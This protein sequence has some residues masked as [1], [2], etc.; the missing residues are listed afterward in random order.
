MKGFYNKIVSYGVA[1]TVGNAETYKRVK[2][3]NIYTLIWIHLTALF[4]ITDC[5]QG[6]LFERMFFGHIVTVF[7]TSSLFFI[8]FLNYKEKYY[9]AKWLFMITALIVFNCSSIIV[10]PGIYTE[11]YFF[12]IPGLSLSLF[13]RQWIS[14]MF[15]VTAV[16]CFFLPYHV[17]E[18]Y[19]VDYSNRID[20]PSMTSLF[21]AIYLLFNYFKKLNQQNEDLLMVER[22]RVI[23]DKVILEKQEKELRELNDFKSHFFVNLS[24]EIRTPLTLIQ[25]YTSQIKEGSGK[26]EI[27]ENVKVIKE[28]TH[29]MQSIINDIMDLSKMDEKQFSIS[30]QEVVVARLLEKLAADF[31]PLFEKKNI[32]FVLEMI[33]DEVVIAVDVDLFQKAIN[34]L[35]TNALKFTASGGRVV[36]KSSFVE[37]GFQIC[38]TDSGIGI[39]SAELSNVFKRFYQVENDITK[40]EGSGIGLAFTKSIVE[41]HHF[42]IRVESKENE[43]TK[44]SI[45]IPEGRYKINSLTE[46]RAEKAVL[47]NS[48]LPSALVFNNEKQSITNKPRILVV[49]DHDQMRKYIQTVLMDYETVEAENGKEALE[50][51]KSQ[52]FDLILTDYMMPVMNGEALVREI[53]K[54]GY[55]TPILVLT[56]RTDNHGK[57][58]MLR[59]GI[60]GYLHKPFLEEELKLQVKNALQLYNNVKTFGDQLDAEERESLNAYAEKFNRKINDFILQHIDSNTLSVEEIAS[61]LNMSRSTLNRKTKAILG[62]NVK[63]LIMEARL[64]KARTF[65]LENPMATK[66]EVSAVV[67]I[68]N[69]TH[70][71]RKLEERFGVCSN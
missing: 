36:L 33:D 71:F 35:L 65:Q 46:Q 58:N 55:N 47:L 44:F 16:F 40:S 32:A 4:T 48:K 43:W 51:I 11:Y 1:S 53:K 39:P 63:D 45:Q 22:D 13:D 29:Q 50:L 57:L 12:L 8:I 69:T 49:E 23:S 64:Q 68:A 26:E 38:I 67:G 59:M 25:G 7:T 37:N 42:K 34:N 9:S 6:I 56:A 15:L 31:K 61:H 62:Q 66:K 17:L 18:I 54:L 70:L 14:I 24:H 30:T 21:V 10:S 2:L 28:Q 5:L 20:Y 60:D 52:T 19:P 41:A 3:L 27:Q